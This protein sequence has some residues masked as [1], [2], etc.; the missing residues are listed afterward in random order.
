MLLA[1]YLALVPPPSLAGQ[2]VVLRELACVPLQA[3]RR[4][5]LPIEG[6]AA[7]DPDSLDLLTT[8][9][10]LRSGRVLV[11]DRRDGAVH[12]FDERGVRVALCVPNEPRSTTVLS[13][14]GDHRGH[15]FLETIHRAEP[16]EPFEVEYAPDGTFLCERP[17]PRD[18]DG[19]LLEIERGFSP[20]EDARWI[21]SEDVRWDW[22]R[23]LTLRFERA[24]RALGSWPRRPDAGPWR[25][26]QG[27]YLDDGRFVVLDRHVHP[28]PSCFGYPTPR[29]RDER[30]FLFVFDAD[31]E[32]V[33]QYRLPDEPDFG[34][35]AGGARRVVLSGA[36]GG[37]MLVDLDT[38]HRT[39]VR[40]Q[41]RAD[42]AANE[43]TTWD[44][45]VRTDGSEELWVVE[46][47]ARRLLRY[48]LP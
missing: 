42:R 33:R 16:P 15:L 24:G 48:A 34:W 29:P 43:R 20:F 45:V 13:L 25:L 44:V 37:W 10:I 4:K 28:V 19:E 9:S 3:P 8:V 6:G 23:D 38:Y 26:G 1:L 39:T 11:S 41:E 2:D 35:S 18:A 21:W 32:F 46:K 7:P 30:Q 47:K 40:I 17:R 27:S 31:G 36:D 14:T 12:V 22:G 5:E